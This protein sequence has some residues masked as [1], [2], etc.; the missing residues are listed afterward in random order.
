MRHKLILSLMLLGLLALAIG[1]LPHRYGKNYSE[2]LFQRT[3]LTFTFTQTL[4]GVISVFQSTQFAIQ[5][6]GMGVNFSAGEI[7]SPLKNLLQKFSGILITCLIFAGLQKM[8][9]QFTASFFMLL[10][11]GATIFYLIVSIWHTKKSWK[12]F[13]QQFATRCCLVV[14]LFYL[15]IPLTAAASALLDFF[16]FQG[17]FQKTY[18]TMES[19]GQQMD[20][21]VPTSLESNT[22]DVGFFERWKTFFSNHLNIKEKMVA[23]KYLWAIS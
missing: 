18:K 6:A 9:L 15:F 19:I 21:E 12:E 22:K 16:Y 14:L 10:L 7:L 2:T 8:L 1:G 11:L 23:Q 4:S 3:L 13:A 5:P 17:E 20:A